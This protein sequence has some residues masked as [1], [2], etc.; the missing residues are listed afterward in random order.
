MGMR[1][2]RSWNKR[3]SVCVICAGAPAS[4]VRRNGCRSL[5]QRWGGLLRRAATLPGR[6]VIIWVSP[7]WPLLSGPEV[8]LTAK[9]ESG[10]FNDVVSF[11]NQLRAAN[12]TLYGVD[13]L[14]AEEG[15]GQTFYYEEF[16]GGV[17]KPSQALL[18]DLGL[19]V[20]A[21]QSGGR[22]LS[23][24]NDVKD[25]LNRCYADTAAFYELSYTPTDTSSSGYHKV[26]V[27]VAEHHLTAHTQQGYYTK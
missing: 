8:Q 11:S 19:Q 13:P 10:I 5:L 25:L 18:G 16:L 22:A 24:S 17:R 20:L 9:E 3:V 6:K 23:S 27:R 15:P 4:T 2:R 14:G 1:W 26:E 21:I 7:G 12:V